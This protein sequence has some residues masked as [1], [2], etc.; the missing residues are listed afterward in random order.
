MKVK[1]FKISAFVISAFPLL[2]VTDAIAL[3]G[4]PPPLPAGGMGPHPGGFMPP[5][6]AGGGFRGAPGFGGGPGVSRPPNFSRAPE[7]SRPPNFSRPQNISPSNFNRMGGLAPNG[8]IAAGANRGPQL[9]PKV[10]SHLKGSGSVLPSIAQG[11]NFRAA[12][13][14]AAFP[15]VS[16]KG[17]GELAQRAQ[18]GAANQ[19]FWN[20]WSKQN[21]GKLANF[22]A[23][24]NKDWNNINEFRKTQNVTASYNKPEWN[25]YKSSVQDYRNNRAIEINNNIRNSFDDHF[26][27]RWWTDRSWN[28]SRGYRD[29]ADRY[30]DFRD[31]DKYWG[32]AEK[33]WWWEAATYG[34]VE[35]FLAL[36]EAYQSDDSSQSEG[37]YQTEGYDYGVNVVYEGDEVYSDGRPIATAKQ[38]SQQATVLANTPTQQPPAPMPPEPV[39]AAEYLPLGVWA[40][41]QEEKGDASTFFQ[42]SIDKNGVVTGAYENLLSG[43]KSPISGQVDKKTQRVAWKIGSN[44]TVI[45]AGL[46]NLTQDVTSC[47]VHFDADATQ[48]WLLVR[49]KDPDMPNAP[50]SGSVADDSK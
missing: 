2:I 4:P 32:Y 38:Y 40:M 9:S 42:I 47:L 22:Q 39:Q 18:G 23:S 34:T 28:S 29:Y 3:F 19:Q 16:G 35:S 37:S 21:E 30:R 15:N 33:Y 14:H 24:R 1:R 12:G 49:L 46:Q 26:N 10:E 5:S 44:N 31:Y 50:Q 43:E 11:K 13:E 41:V 20:N 48:T 27:S 8:K 17:G 6:V 7:F 45:E 25:N 36:D